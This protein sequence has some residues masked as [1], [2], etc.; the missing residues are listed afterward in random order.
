MMG[1]SSLL[2][3]IAKI[4]IEKLIGK[5]NKPIKALGNDYED[6]LARISH[7]DFSKWG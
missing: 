5:A 6:K 7:K 1:A 4:I 3:P 2:L